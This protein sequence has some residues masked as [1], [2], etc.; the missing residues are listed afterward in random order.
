MNASYCEQVRRAAMARA[1]AEPAALSC[2]EIEDHLRDCPECRQEVERLASLA[3]AFAARRRQ[4]QSPNLWPAIRDKLTGEAVC[5]RDA[6]AGRWLLALALILF[7]FRGFVLA[8]GTSLVWQVKLLALMLVAGVFF[9]RRENPFA[10]N[11][12]LAAREE[13]P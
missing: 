9:L 10:L 11:P 13:K 4:R 8:N 12:Q 2:A 1:D 7:C 6:G 3:G 5:R